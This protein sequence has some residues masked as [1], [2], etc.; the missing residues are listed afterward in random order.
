MAKALIISTNSGV[1]TDEILKTGKLL[2]EAGVETTFAA[3]EKGEIK[4]LVLDEKPGESAEA[5]A[6]LA[7]VSADDYDALVVPGGTLNADNLR[8]NSDAVALVQ[9]FTQQKKVVAGICHAGWL[10]INAHIVDGVK[11]TSIPNIR[12]DLGNAGAEWKDAEVVV[13][14][15]KGY[16]VVTSRN[17]GDIEAF[18]AK[19]AELAK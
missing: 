7:E 8:M 18:S 12:T 17:P 13:D 4:T 10:F 15:S 9:A 1:E 3:E 11:M 19:I 16:T 2:A 6:T 14:D 5:T